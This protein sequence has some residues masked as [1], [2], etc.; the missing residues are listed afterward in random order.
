MSELVDVVDAF[1]NPIKI[2]WVIW[3]AW[4]IGLVFWCR[5]ERTTRAL[6]APT[7]DPEVPAQ[8]IV[9]ERDLAPVEQGLVTPEPVLEA[10]PAVAESMAPAAET[11]SSI[12]PPVPAFD[13]STAVVETF[14]E[15]A[16]DLDQFIADF[17]RGMP[18]EPLARSHTPESRA[19]SRFRAETPQSSYTAR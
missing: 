6:G 18:S 15:T 2:G 4:G 7:A 10:A 1:S 11:L 17:E 5:H 19:G 8:A 13:P 16:S 14:A 12:R 9:S 3:F